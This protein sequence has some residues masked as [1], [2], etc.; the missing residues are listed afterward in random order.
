MSAKSIADAVGADDWYAAAQTKNMGTN[1][2]WSTAMVP[3]VDT[4]KMRDPRRL[5]CAAIVSPGM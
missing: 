2:L 4:E 3:C 1:E 5:T